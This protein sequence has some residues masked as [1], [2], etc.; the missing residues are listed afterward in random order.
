MGTQARHRQC[1]E[2][3]NGSQIACFERFNIEMTQEQAYYA[4]HPGNCD[5]DVEELI[6]NPDILK[7]LDAISPDEI[8]DELAEWGAWDNEELSNDAE[9]R[10]RIV[11]IAAGNISEESESYN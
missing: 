10:L 5:E 1:E 9:N 4:S 6:A 8:R 3:D 11:W 7:Q 2:I